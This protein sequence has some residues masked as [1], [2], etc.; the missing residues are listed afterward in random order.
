M[1]VVSR[2]GLNQILKGLDAETIREVNAWYKV[3]RG[4]DWKDL[5]AVQRQFPS[6]DQV[7][8]ALI[9]DIRRNRYRLITTVYFPGRTLYIKALLTHKVYDRKEWMKWA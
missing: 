6:V 3:A 9:F 7:G 2:R 1:N 4:A 5:A 8:H